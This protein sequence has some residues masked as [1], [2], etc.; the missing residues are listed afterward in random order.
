MWKFKPG[1]I[2][3]EKTKLLHKKYYNLEIK[4]FKES[5]PEKNRSVDMEFNLTL[6]DGKINMNCGICGKFLHPFIK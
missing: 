6:E 4:H 2:A 3:E 5:H 1:R